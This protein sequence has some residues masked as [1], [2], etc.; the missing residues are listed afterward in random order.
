MSL[1]GIAKET[2]A[3]LEAGTYVSPSGAERSIAGAQAAALA[4]TRLITPAEGADLL[5]RPGSDGPP[6]TLS[7]ANERAQEAAQRMAADG[8]VLLL[9]FASA[10]NAGGG[11]VNGAKAQEEDIARCSGLVP[12]LLRQPAYYEA[13]RSDPSP[14]YTD[15]VIYSPGVPFFRVRS[16]TRIEHPFVADIITAPAPN[17][18]VARRRG[19]PE[20]VIEQTLVRRAGIV[21]ALAQDVGAR[22]LLL[23]AWGCGVFQN[24]PR[25]CARTFVALL[26]S[27]RFAGA[28]DTVH[29]A[30]LDRGKK[31]TLAAFEA[32]VGQRDHGDRSRS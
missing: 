2:L 1:K 32:A 29:F 25:V 5:A 14:L 4:G 17:A 21:L 12:C 24:D 11:F 26:H 18:G 3:I 9:N 20:D 19:I 8:R 27:A 23:G 30:V 22:R 6:P 28:F 10:R 16:R 7:V 15:H 13:N 31:A